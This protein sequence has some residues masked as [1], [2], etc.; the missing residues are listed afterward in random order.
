MLQLLRLIYSGVFDRHPELQV[1]VGHWG[2]L[3]LFFVERI[4]VLD[5]LGR[6]LDRSLAEYLK[7]NVYYTG[8]ILSERYL[9]W[10]IE[11]VGVDR[12]MYATDY[13]HLTSSDGQL[14]AA[15]GRARSFLE[16]APMSS[17]D[18]EKIAHGNWERL[19]AR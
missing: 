16:Q 7:D 17:Q 10:T 6:D 4:Q 1:I 19:T 9:R 8:G 2:E 15:N 13:P 3:V 5:G 11:V 12:V 18:R 14:D